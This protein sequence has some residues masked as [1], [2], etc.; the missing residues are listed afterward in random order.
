MRR[1]VFPYHGEAIAEGP[2]LKQSGGFCQSRRSDL[3]STG[4]GGVPPNKR[5]RIESDAHERISGLFVLA[6]REGLAAGA[7][8]AAG[9]EMVAEK[10]FTII[11]LEGSK[12]SS[13]YSLLDQGKGPQ[14][15]LSPHL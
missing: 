1:H 6:R 12:H 9:A 4:V 7:R 15:H 10:R 5:K 2:F 13:V 11:R 8:K 14:D 3:S